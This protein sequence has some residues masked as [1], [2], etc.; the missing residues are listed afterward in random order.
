MAKRCIAPFVTMTN[1][2]PRVIS[3]GAIVAD[4]DP[5]IAGRERN[6]EDIESAV[7]RSVAQVEQ[8]TA[9]P[10]ERRQGPKRRR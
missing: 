4:D 2:V 5:A 8:A 1:G 9:A 7:A 3:A 10:G 6:F